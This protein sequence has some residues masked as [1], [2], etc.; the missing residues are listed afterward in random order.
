MREAYVVGAV[1]HNGCLGFQLRDSCAVHGLDRWPRA[2]PLLQ[3]E[4]LGFWLL[5]VVNC[6]FSVCLFGTRGI[7]ELDASVEQWLLTKKT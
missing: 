4:V 7:A 6:A 3:I 1:K 5:F 2:L